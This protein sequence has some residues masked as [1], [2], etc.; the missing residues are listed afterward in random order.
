MVISTGGASKGL[1]SKIS[2]SP[3]TSNTNKPS[4]SRTGKSESKNNSNQTEESYLDN[5]ENTA[6]SNAV[7]GSHEAQAGAELSRF[8][9]VMAGITSPGKD[10][11]EGLAD[12]GPYA[13]MSQQQQAQQALGGA[14]QGGGSGGIGD[15]GSDWKDQGATDE[16]GIRDDGGDIGEGIQE[17]NNND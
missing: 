10:F 16:D 14:G 11:T 12:P 17:R 5:A 15:L 4:I 3:K 2:V 13:A 6:P 1:S 9:S 8:K 7:S